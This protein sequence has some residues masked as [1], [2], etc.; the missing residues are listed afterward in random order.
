MNS[1]QF[2]D[3]F[4]PLRSLNFRNVLF[5]VMICNPTVSLASR[6][7]SQEQI[8][9]LF[10]IASI[11]SHSNNEIP[12]KMVLHNPYVDQSAAHSYCLG[13]AGG[14]DVSPKNTACLFGVLQMESTYFKRFRMEV[15]IVAARSAIGIPDGYRLVPWNDSLLEIHARTKHRSFRDE[16]DSMV[17]PCLGDAE[18]CRRL[19]QEIRLKPG[20]LADATWLISWGH[21][22]E[23]LQWCGTI[24]GITDRSG[25][26]SIQNIGV[27]PGHRGRGLGTVLIERAIL[28]FLAHGMRKASLE[29]TA[30]NQAAVR[31]YRRLGFRKYSTV[32][33]VSEP[34]S[35][36]PACL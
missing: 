11:K 30:D 18:G 26:G 19:M 4:K 28:G 13:M 12:Q 16:I 17:F 14:L 36:E 20:F 32:Y 8:R 10:R 22:P 33:K 7:D 31:L 9:G 25:M 1:M 24:Q 15:D 21:S 27:V 35:S 6:G 23:E 29:V 5:G 34:V 3:F 2:H